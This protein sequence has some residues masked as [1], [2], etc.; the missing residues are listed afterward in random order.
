[1]SFVRL[2]TVGISL[3][4]GIFC[5]SLLAC[6]AWLTASA[7]ETPAPSGPVEASLSPPRLPA[8]TEVT[9]QAT[10][11]AAEKPLFHVDR[12]PF[13]GGPAAAEETVAEEAGNVSAFIL[14]GVLVSDTLERASIAAAAAG[15]AQW[16]NRGEVFQGWTLVSVEAEEILLV[17]D[18]EQT[19][20][21][22]RPGRA[23]PAYEE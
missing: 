15:K 9:D 5:A 16:V 12:K 23:A 3:L 11:M 8:L 1:M 2:P 10:G 4:L 19:T 7:S 14:R 22:L 18:G 21:S 17:R 13:L 6:L 20:L